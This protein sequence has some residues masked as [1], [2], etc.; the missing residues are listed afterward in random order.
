[1]YFFRL[2]ILKQ[3]PIR[4]ISIFDNNITQ[5]DVMDPILLSIYCIFLPFNSLLLRTQLNYKTRVI[6]KLSNSLKDIEIAK[7]NWK[8]LYN[9]SIQ[10]IQKK[11][12]IKKKTTHCLEICTTF[13]VEKI[14]IWTNYKL[15]LRHLILEK[16]CFAI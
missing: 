5:N 10:A 14:C 9:A 8:Q 15:E 13:K 2:N 7:N 6:I 11:E 3:K 4:D 1:M 12:N 16:H